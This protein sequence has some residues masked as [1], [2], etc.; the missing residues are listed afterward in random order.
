M[1]KSIHKIVLTGPP[2]SGKSTAISR[3][4]EFVNS[5]GVRAVSA[6]EAATEL[7][8]N[9]ITPENYKDPAMFQTF[10]IEKLLFNESFFTRALRHSKGVM[11]N[12]GIVVCD[13]GLHD[14]LAYSDKESV[15]RTLFVHHELSLE[16]EIS[17]RYAMAIF[18]DVAP[19]KYYTNQNNS[20]R[21]ETYTEALLLGSKTA[22]AWV[23]HPNL[24]LVGNNYD[25]FDGKVN[26]VIQNVAQLVGVPE[27]LAIE[28]KYLVRDR[29]SIVLEKFLERK[30]AVC[31]NIVQHYLIGDG[32]E[33]VRA[34]TRDSVTTYFHTKKSN[35]PSVQRIKTE[36]IISRAKY[37]ELL[38]SADP[39][40]APIEK[41]RHY[42]IDNNQYFRLDTFPHNS[43]AHLLE[44]QPTT[45][46]EHITLPD[47][48]SCCAIEVT[49]EAMYYNYNIA[50]ELEKQRRL[51]N[52]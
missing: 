20:A 46:Q 1:N 2:C 35:E 22:T 23:G 8:I 6:P 17:S 40:C 51:V 9:G 12:G 48:L 7:K 45:E 41:V 30:Q 16:K 39:E 49:D 27:P 42:F 3:V 26:A 14:C 50:R 29:Q 25:D 32:E 37:E 28:R 24:I 34:W 19:K 31:V 52:E 21:E 10:L 5:L 43:G 13:R 18:M 38:R 47:C 15:E 4:V 11:E 44:V 36:K 33:R